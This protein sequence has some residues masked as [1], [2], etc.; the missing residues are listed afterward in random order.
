MERGRECEVVAL[1]AIE[2]RSGVGGALLAEAVERARRAGC[3]R[4]F[5]TTS[6]D[7]LDAM[8]FYQR[9]G[10]RL[11]AVYPGSLERARAERPHLHEIGHHGI[12][13]RDDV[14]FEVRLEE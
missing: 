2:P 9:R 10:W 13:I 11:C 14:E 8:R 1:V 7:N 4:V 5:L 3:S 6:N 12:P